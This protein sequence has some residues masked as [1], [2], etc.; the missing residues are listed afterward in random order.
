M[1]AYRST[2]IDVSRK[3]RSIGNCW[4]A[5]PTSDSVRQDLLFCRSVGHPTEVAR[6]A[7]TQIEIFRRMEYNRN[8]KYPFVYLYHYRQV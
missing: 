4:S 6:L 2:I 8:R 1:G 3:M 7:A 5:H